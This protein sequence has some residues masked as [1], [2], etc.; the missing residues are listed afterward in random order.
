MKARTTIIMIGMVLFA[1]LTAARAAPG[2][3]RFCG[4]SYD[5]WDR[6][7]MAASAG[8]GGALVSLASGTDQTFTWNAANPALAV[9]TIEAEDPAGT[10]TNGGAMRVTVPAA[11]AC[12]FDTSVSVTYGGDA[13]GKVGAA[14]FLD[15][16]RTLNIPVTADFIAGDTLT[17][18]GLKLLDLAL[19]P[20]GTQWLELDFTGDGTRDVYDGNSLALTVPWPGGSYD[21]WDRYVLAESASLDATRRGTVF[22]LSRLMRGSGCR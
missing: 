11:W 20:S 21:G 13:A 10:I 18:S 1:T 15:G 4:G 5:G 9:L 6:D 19:C 17:L 14:S 2:D 16:G 8:L 22:M 12:R 3:E 7:V